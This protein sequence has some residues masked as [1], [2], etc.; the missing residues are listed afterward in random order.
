MNPRNIQQLRNEGYDNIADELEK[1]VELE[2]KIGILEK[3]LSEFKNPKN[4]T[5]S[6]DC[7]GDL[8][9]QHALYIPKLINEE[10]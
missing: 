7:K 5:R 10:R 1:I 3:E 9:S 4:W 6:Y 2:E 8:L